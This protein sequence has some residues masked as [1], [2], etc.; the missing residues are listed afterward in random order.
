MTDVVNL[1]KNTTLVD[2]NLPTE[3]MCDPSAYAKQT[4]ANWKSISLF[5]EKCYIIDNFPCPTLTGETGHEL[6]SQ[7]VFAWNR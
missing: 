6:R 2:H 5:V 3:V 7:L 1:G 4:A